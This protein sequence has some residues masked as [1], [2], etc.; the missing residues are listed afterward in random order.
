MALLLPAAL[1]LNGLV[2]GMLLWS[3]IGGVPWMRELSGPEYV[4]LHR[5]WSPRFDPL[6]PICV[7]LTLAATVALTVLAERAPVRVALIVAVVALI[8]V[9]VVSAT[10]SAPIKK[11]VLR[12]DPDR[13]PADWESRDPRAGWE[14]WNLAR[15]VLAIGAFFAE[16]VA[17]GLAL[18]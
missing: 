11:R 3:V 9:M 12:L 10:R 7:A 15:S 18:R 5:F 6:A 4:R 2:A 16:L 8:A 13:M 14:R 17:A 1:L